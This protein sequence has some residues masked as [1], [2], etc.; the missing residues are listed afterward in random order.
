MPDRRG[1]Q[2]R[3]YSHRPPRP[4]STPLARPYTTSLLPYMASP[5]QPLTIADEGLRL[6]RV[7]R[8]LF[9]AVWIIP[10]VLASLQ[11]T[12]VGDASGAHYGI[13]TALIWQ[14]STWLLWSLWSQ[15]ILTLVD[16][17]KLDTARLLPWLTVHI[18]ASALVCI[19]DVFVIAWL[20]HVF[21]AVGQ[22]TSYA[23]TL[24]VVLVNH[25]DFQVV[26]Y[27]AVLGAAYM[28][29]FVRRY[30]ERDRAATELEQKLA[31][32]QLEALRMQLNPHFLFNALNSVAELMEMDVREA[33]RTLTRVS[34][35]LR[36]SLRSAGQ[37]MIPVW[38]EIELVELYLQIARVRY[39]AG[40]E[41]DITVDPSIVDDMVPSFLMQPLVENALKHGLA[42]GHRD[43]CI[44]VRVGRQG[45]TI[46]IVVQDNGKG[47][48]GLLTTSGRFL[49]A[50]PSVDGLGIGLTN[51]RSRL[52]MLYGDRYAFRMS[53][54]P[55]G[56]CRVEIR[57]PME[58]R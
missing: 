37:P 57:L 42:P 26:L 48:D 6:R 47:L 44:E 40:L 52:T 1:F 5:T 21:G 14:G 4:A 10:A 43:Q 16:R 25:L 55:T 20:D 45:S 49:A 29:E 39:G 50:V 8:I 54:L 9:A 38:Q 58:P 46:E 27:W 36:L 17:V 41:A 56:G 33:Q 2:L 15:L 11:M 12:L 18:V 23:F 32:T 35:L 51:T 3:W 53:N 34:D 19:I 24:R 30:R 7:T 22:V 28:V 13:G 31:R